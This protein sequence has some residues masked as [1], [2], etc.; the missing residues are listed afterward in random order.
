MC[1]C[2]TEID[3]V[4]GRCALVLDSIRL[5]FFYVDAPEGGTEKK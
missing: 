2:I 1:L 4:N 3:E 5:L